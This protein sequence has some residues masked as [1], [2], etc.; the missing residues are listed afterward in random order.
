MSCQTCSSELTSTSIKTSFI[1]PCCTTPICGNCIKRNPRL[2][3]YIP[4]L[5]CGDP[6]THELRGGGRNNL[7]RNNNGG[8]NT[9]QGEEVVFEIGDDDDEEEEELDLPPNYD[10][11]SP[12][13]NL[14][15]NID[16]PNSNQ[17]DDVSNNDIP[18]DEP[19]QDEEDYEIVEITHKVQ[20]GDTILSIA[21]KYASDPHELLLLN[22]IPFEAI[23][24]HSRIIQTRKSIIISNR[25][26]LKSKITQKS[27]FDQQQQQQEEETKVK[28]E[29]EKQRQI[30]KFQLLTKN[31]DSNIANTYLNLSELEE[32]FFI[33]NKFNH[34]SGETINGNKKKQLKIDKLNREQRALESFFDDENWESQNKLNKL[35]PSSSTTSSSSRNTKWNIINGFGNIKI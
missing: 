24:N 15:Q 10:D 18:S 27:Q 17:A 13:N 28:Q 14:F 19:S 5:R 11:I 20:K 22:K 8:N 32:S 30:K 9:I 16:N 25:K 6:R 1:T 33:N 2:K 23:S 34:D 12:S 35:I 3:E 26:I 31:L 4:C 7:L 29:R 21:R